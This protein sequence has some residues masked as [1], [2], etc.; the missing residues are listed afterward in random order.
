MSG[1][2]FR[3]HTVRAQDMKYEKKAWYV[4]KWAH[5]TASSEV[6]VSAGLWSSLWFSLSFVPFWVTFT[7]VT[8]VLTQLDDVGVSDYLQKHI[9]Y[10][11]TQRELWKYDLGQDN[12]LVS[13][14]VLQDRPRDVARRSMEILK[15]GEKNVKEMFSSRDWRK[16]DVHVGKKKVSWHEKQKRIKQQEMGG[17]MRGGEH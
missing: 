9:S 17:I 8:A 6:F 10:Q 3:L 5:N 4:Y 12:V 13:S 2:I 15:W 14:V 11:I 16:W 7:I 1:R